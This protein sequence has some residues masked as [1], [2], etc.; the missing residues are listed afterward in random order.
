M[1]FFAHILTLISFF[2][3]LILVVI[4]FKD[5]NMNEYLKNNFITN[6]HIS[7]EKKHY[8]SKVYSHC[9]D[10]FELEYV[11]SGAGTYT[12]DGI[13]YGIG[14]RTLYFMTPVNFHQIDMK[15][16]F[17]YNVMFSADACDLSVLSRL[18]SDS[19]IVLS[20][21]N[22]DDLF[23]CALLDELCSCQND[24]E[25]SSI[26]LESIV[27]KISTLACSKRK[28]DMSADIRNTKLYIIENFKKNLTLSDV[29]R[30][31]MLSE[32][33]FSRKFSREV[34][35][36]FKEYLNTVRFDHAKNLLEYSELTVMQICSE[37]GFNDYPN[38]IRRFRQ[39]FGQSPMEYKNSKDGKKVHN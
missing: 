19:P 31:A 15:D 35:K 14:D 21:N 1:S 18:F 4:C 28:N 6:G 16:T 25:Y 7:A 23:L 8:N 39:H 9:H 30:N 11:V 26:I 17:F 32:S 37:C 20:V 3:I 34:G 27:Y 38:F 29:A 13:D 24:I 22:K 12:I 5:N 10:F 33:H 36:S 2:D